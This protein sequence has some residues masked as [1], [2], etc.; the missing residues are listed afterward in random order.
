MEHGIHTSR[1]QYWAH[2]V[3]PRRKLCRYPVNQMRLHIERND[4]N[5]I[6]GHSKDGAVTGWGYLVRQDEPFI[7]STPVAEHYFRDF[8][9]EH[10]RDLGLRGQA[11][12]ARILRDQHHIVEMIDT[13]E[14]QL[15]EGYDALVDGRRVEFKTEG[16]DSANLFV[17][18]DEHDHRPTVGG[19][20]TSM[21]GLRYQQNRPNLSFVGY[22][23]HGRFLHYCHCGE[24]GAYGYGVNRAIGELGRWYCARHKPEEGNQ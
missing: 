6:P 21:P 19:Q 4:L 24:W 20:Y 1:A 2:L 11:L 8:A 23:P 12:I 9:Y 16:Y 22:D 5:V 10:D 13:R 14:A 15:L 7:K 17:Q 3:V 18:K